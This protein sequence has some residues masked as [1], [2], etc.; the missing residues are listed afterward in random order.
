[1]PRLRNNAEPAAA[2]KFRAPAHWASLDLLRY[3]SF[4]IVVSELPAVFCNIILAGLCSIKKLAD[5]AHGI[6]FPLLCDVTV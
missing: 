6:P 2:A 1:M 3:Q 4:T 5:S